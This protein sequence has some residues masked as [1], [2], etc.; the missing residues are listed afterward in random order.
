MVLVIYGDTVGSLRQKLIS[1]KDREIL[2]GTLLGDGFL[3]QMK[4]GKSRL[5]VGHTTSQKEYLEWKYHSF[6]RFTKAKPHLVSFYD[7]RYRKKYFQWRFKTCADSFFNPFYS[8]FYNKEGKKIIRKSIVKI[9]NSPLSLAVWFMDDGGRRNDSY[10]MFLNTLSFSEHEHETLREC[11]LKNFSISTRIHSIQCGKRLY[12]PSDQAINFAKIVYPHLIPSM[13]YKL[14]YNP[15]TTS[16]ARLD[17]A[18]DRGKSKKV[19]T[20]RKT[21]L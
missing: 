13:R 14:S 16:F 2:F 18:R 10:G 12:I 6:T 7:K 17:R 9:F 3:Y 21:P 19:K 4:N 15:V 11:L 8:Y 1:T 5:E 20:E